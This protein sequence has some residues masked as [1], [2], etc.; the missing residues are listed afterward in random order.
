MKSIILSCEG[1]TLSDAEKALFKAADPLGFIL[2]KRNIDNPEQ[3][4]ALTASLRESVGRADCPILIDQEGGRVQRMS[5]PHWPQYPSAKEC[6]DVPTV[7]AAI[8]RDL[9]EVG[10]DVNCIPVLDILFPETHQAIGNRA[11]ADTADEVFR[12]GKQAI[13]A[14]LDAGVTPVMKHIPGQGRAALDSHYDLPRVEAS[15]D[16]LRAV[17]FEPFARMAEEAF[18]PQVWGM[19]SHILYS[20]IDTDRPA[21]VSAKVIEIIRKELHFDG[22]LLSDDVSMGALSAFGPPE[23]RCKAMLEA[24]C[25]VALYCAGKLDE[26]QKIAES[27]PRIRPESIDR[28]ERSRV[29]RRPAA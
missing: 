18:A 10:I 11:Y 21:S 28:Y 16:D 2:F 14:H 24:G 22:L 15:L 6:D 1:T 26:M 4:S 25:D 8:A 19:V 9:V 29:R 3:L 20:A 13:C 17:D 7:A 23:D 5:V 12:K 27:A